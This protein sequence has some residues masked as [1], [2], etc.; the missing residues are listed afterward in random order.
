MDGAAPLDLFLGARASDVKLDLKLSSSALAPQGR[1]GVKSRSW[2]DGFLGARLAFPCGERWMLSGY[3][4]IGGGG[5]DSTWQLAAGADY[6]F[7]PAASA[8]FGYRLLKV[9]YHRDDFLYDLSSGGP[10]AGVAIRF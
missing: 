5:S 2:V 1:S 9:D 10:Y 3:A 7:S 8:K 4:D 6:A